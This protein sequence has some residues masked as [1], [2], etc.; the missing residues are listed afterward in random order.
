MDDVHRYGICTLFYGQV[1]FK[2]AL[3]QMVYSVTNTT[4]FD[5]LSLWT[6]AISG[7]NYL[8]SDLVGPLLM[9]GMQQYLGHRCCTTCPLK[10]C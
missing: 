8:W 5:C 9:D 10:Q 2:V 3:V 6:N 7:V 1:Q 4:M